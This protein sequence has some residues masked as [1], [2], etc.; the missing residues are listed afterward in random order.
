MALI[1]VFGSEGEYCA[2]ILLILIDVEEKHEITEGTR[3]M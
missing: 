3:E 2:G 1:R